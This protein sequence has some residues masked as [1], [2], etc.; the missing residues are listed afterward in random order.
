[1]ET[2]E[3]P[4]IRH[5]GK[6][7]VTDPP[8]RH[9]DIMIVMYFTFKLG[10][11]ALEDQGFLTSTGRFVDRYE[12]FEIAKESGQLSPTLTRVTIPAELNSFDVWPPDF[13]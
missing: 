2:I 7:Y 13:E 8:G 10:A 11:K 4:A 5:D 1:M 9:L 6:L 3:K 12:A